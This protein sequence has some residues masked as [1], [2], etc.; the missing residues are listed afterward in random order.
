MSGSDARPAPANFIAEIAEKE[1]SEGRFD[2]QVVTR[3][4]PE[5]NG[6]LHIGHAFAI[7]VSWSLAQKHGGRFHLRFDDTNPTKEDVRY[8]E[9]QQRDMRW[10][11]VDW[12]DNLFYASDYFGQMVEYAKQLIRQGQA[13]VCHLDAEAIKA[14]RGNYKVPGTP[15]PYRDRSV[16]ENL[17]EFQKMIDGAYKEG[18]AVLRAKIDLAHTNTLMRDPIMYRIHH[19]HHYRQGDKWCVY[20]MYDWAHCL[21]DSIEGVTYSLCSIEFQNNRVLYDWYL[22]QLGVHHPQQLE[23]AKM[24]ISHTVMGKRKLLQLVEEGRVMG[25]DDP[26]MPTLSGLRRR[27]FTPEAMASFLSEIGVTK[28]PTFVDIALLEHHVR[29]DLNAR[30]LRV[31]GV[32]D[33]LKLTVTT[34]PEGETEWCSVDN[35]PEDESAGKRKIPFTRELWVEREDV[36]EQANRKW[37]RLAPGREVRLKGAYYVTLDEIVKDPDTGEIIELRCSHDPASKG[38]WTDDG[39]KVKG[40]LHWVSAAHA[41]DAEVRLI[42]RLF[43]VWNPYEVEEG[44]TWK[45]HLNPESLTVLTGCKLEPSLAEAQPGTPLQFLRKGYFCVDSEDSAPGA[46]VFNRTIALRDSWKGR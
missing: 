36:R 42:D 27:G 43:S 20:P 2:G 45:D 38:G 12:G 21:E 6:F 16:E 9:S 34:F 23:F 31:M 22:D 17:A 11:G 4:P 3:F 1:L 35:N 41:V 28:S 13:F 29:Q 46:L 8:V 26:R 24:S 14:G 5:P 10:L 33:P 39:R 44:Q 32:L 18:E 19:A 15:S 40:T 25:W 7:N 37:R 30:A